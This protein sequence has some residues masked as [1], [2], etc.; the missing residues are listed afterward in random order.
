M[1]KYA[2]QDLDLQHLLSHRAMVMIMM[3]MMM[4][5][6][7]THTPGLLTGGSHYALPSSVSA[8]P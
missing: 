2:D 3:M 6:M 4:M 5:M 8:F 1:M 7:H